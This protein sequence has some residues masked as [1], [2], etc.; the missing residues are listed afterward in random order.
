MDDLVR[1]EQQIN[2][3]LSRYGV[4]FGN[5]KN[6]QFQERLFP[7]DAIPRVI[8]PRNGTIWRRD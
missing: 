2:Q 1:H 5:Y 7:F 3:Q 6:G 4:K 8:P